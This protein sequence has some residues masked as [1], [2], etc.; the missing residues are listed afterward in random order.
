MEQ[1]EFSGKWAEP[2]LITFAMHA[3]RAHVGDGGGVVICGDTGLREHLAAGL[4]SLAGGALVGD[5]I[6]VQAA[7]ARLA[8]ESGLGVILFTA[9]EP[10]AVLALMA[11]AETSQ[12]WGRDRGALSFTDVV[13]RFVLVRYDVA[14]QMFLL[15]RG[16]LTEVACLSS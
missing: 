15:T 12:G 13:Q 7:R 1:R 9:M 2:D 11:S 10:T 5:L 4:G 16:S 14:A 8:G 3:E 6:Y